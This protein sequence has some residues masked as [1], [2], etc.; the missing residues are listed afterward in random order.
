M[1]T[2]LLII[3][4]IAYIFIGLTVYNYL[5]KNGNRSFLAAVSVTAVELM[6]AIKEADDG[7]A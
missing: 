6:K 3:G 4:L 7:T 1:T 2:L 5:A